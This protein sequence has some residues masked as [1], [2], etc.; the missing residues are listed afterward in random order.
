[1][2]IIL[3]RYYGLLSQI[4]SIA[5]DRGRAFLESIKINIAQDSLN[6]MIMHGTHVLWVRH[7]KHFS[8][9][10]LISYVHAVDR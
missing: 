3:I 6:N 10:S 8:S 2:F 9:G 5:L 1:M 4:Q 7:L